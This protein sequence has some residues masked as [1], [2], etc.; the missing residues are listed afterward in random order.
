MGVWATLAVTGATWN[1]SGSV[2]V[3][4]DPAVGL[5]L[6]VSFSGEDRGS[7]G[8]ASGRPGTEF[9]T[10]QKSSGHQVAL[11][12]GATHQYVL[13]GSDKYK[14]QPG[15]VTTHDAT[16]RGSWSPYYTNSPP[17]SIPPTISGPSYPASEVS[18]VSGQTYVKGSTVTV[19]YTG[20]D[21]GGSGLAGISIDGGSL[22]SSPAS[23]TYTVTADFTST[24]YA[25]DGAGNQS[26][27]VSKAFKF[28]N[29]A[30]TFT[31]V[32]PS[33][34]SDP[35]DTAGNPITGLFKELTDSSAT[36]DVSISDSMSGPVKFQ[37][38]INEYEF[39]GSSL[40]SPTN[41]PWEDAGT[42]ESI[43]LG[44]E[45]VYEIEVQKATDVAGNESTGTET[46]GK[47]IIIEEEDAGDSAPTT[48]TVTPGC[49]DYWQAGLPQSGIIS[50]DDIKTSQKVID[51]IKDVYGMTDAEV[52][53][54]WTWHTDMFALPHS[55]PMHSAITSTEQSTG[56]SSNAFASSVGALTG[57]RGGWFSGLYGRGHNG[58]SQYTACWLGRRSSGAPQPVL[59]H[60]SIYGEF[61]GY[62]TYGGWNTGT[63]GIRG[64]G[65]DRGGDVNVNMH[66]KRDAFI[67]EAVAAWAPGSTFPVSSHASAA[68]YSGKPCGIDWMLEKLD[69]LP[70][71]GGNFKIEDCIAPII[72]SLHVVSKTVF[73]ANG[74][75][76]YVDYPNT[77]HMCHF[78][79]EAT[80]L[81]YGLKEA[82]FTPYIDGAAQP[83]ETFPFASSQS[84]ETAG[85]LI[86]NTEGA[87][88][89]WCDVKVID[90][91]DPTGNEAT[92]SMTS[93]KISIDDGEPQGGTVAG[94]GQTNASNSTTTPGLKL[95]NPGWMVGSKPYY[96]ALS[97]EIM[98]EYED[99]YSGIAEA[100][101]YINGA[102]DG[103]V[104][105][106][107]TE[108]A[109]VY[110]G[111]HTVTNLN[112]GINNAQLY[113]KDLATN[114]WFSGVLEFYID[115]TT[116]DAYIQFSPPA[117][118]YELRANRNGELWTKENNV[119]VDL[120]YGDSGPDPSGVYKGATRV[121]GPP[122]NM[123]TVYTGNSKL[124]HN[125]QGLDIGQNDIYFA[126]EDKTD[127]PETT[128][129]MVTCHLD[130]TPPTGSIVRNSGQ[131]VNVHNSLEY[132]NTTNFNVDLTHDD[133]DSLL[134]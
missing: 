89:V 99:E 27:S 13:P 68:Q 127:H 110:N 86:I 105:L 88:E 80:D 39:D 14:F 37:Y 24:A 95:V 78:E 59:E 17:D 71:G 69:L 130:Q 3:V 2:Y 72:N 48:V 28:D 22:Q 6:S 107:T 60:L 93:S 64:R 124:K 85:P 16:R 63:G 87:S 81:E 120:F 82:I 40:G 123:T 121:G 42:S 128:T 133:A 23:K 92:D 108:T 57:R 112:E 32:D 111:T 134:F 49:K 96:D 101:L 94:N 122:S 90:L 102:V 54:L 113:L 35:V 103:S 109:E 19:T 66:R 38:R 1:A 34:G 61:W 131:F 115:M 104:S 43:P 21:S 51:K 47:F 97:V 41:G 20:S 12:N 118:N 18:E 56:S 36:V 7:S 65:T 76:Y 126:L 70:Q 46:S 116:P 100:K 52:A 58:S 26:G 74:K 84:K 119:N 25:K 11:L 9:V 50:F 83:D 10:V 98:V 132:T 67:M 31:I 53:A 5:S 55:D 117:D 73:A 29:I 91:A 15:V 77:N 125:Q 129:P 44:P 8:D 4:D 45:F 114:E 30:P 62:S 79:V 106:P 33:G 75:E